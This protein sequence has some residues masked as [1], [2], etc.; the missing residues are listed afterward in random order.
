MK[1]I[2]DDTLILEIENLLK[3]RNN[4]S[5]S[6]EMVETKL[7]YQKMKYL[8]CFKYISE[9]NIQEETQRMI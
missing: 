8:S 9:E 5:E 3:N 2:P 1:L 7:K 4:E 6:T